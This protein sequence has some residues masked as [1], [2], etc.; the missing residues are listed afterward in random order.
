[1]DIGKIVNKFWSEDFPNSTELVINSEDKR[2]LVTAMTD[3]S[4]LSIGNYKIYCGMKTVIDNDR[5]YYSLTF[6]FDKK[7]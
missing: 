2:L 1:M 3:Y 7:Y 5:K 6:S 4:K